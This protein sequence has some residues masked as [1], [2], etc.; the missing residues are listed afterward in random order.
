MLLP[1]PINLNFLFFH[2]A[3][4]LFNGENGA[5]ELLEKKLTGGGIEMSESSI[6]LLID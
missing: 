3:R 1:H 2:H 6:G 4:V 5:V